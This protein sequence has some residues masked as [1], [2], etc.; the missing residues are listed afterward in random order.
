MQHR[1]GGAFCVVEVDVATRHREPVR[2]AN[3]RTTD[4]GDRQRKVAG[5]L[6][7]HRELLEVLLAEV[8]RR[9]AHEVK[10]PADDQRNAS[11][12]TGPAAVLKP[13]HGCDIGKGERRRLHPRRLEPARV[14][15]L[16]RRHEDRSHAERLE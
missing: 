1:R 2:L 14:D 11:E 9:R 12:V 15:R 5:H 6:A 13:G 7:H 3:G 16:D 4:H 10:Q 8:R